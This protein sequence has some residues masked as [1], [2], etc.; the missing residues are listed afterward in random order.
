MPTIPQPKHKRF[1]SRWWFWVGL[2]VLLTLLG[3]GIYS[4]STAGKSLTAYQYLQE[5]VTV[6]TRDLD[7]RITANGSVVPDQSTSLS[8]NLPG[9]VKDI[10]VNVGDEVDKDEVLIQASSEKIK[11][12]FDGRV[13]AIQ[14]FVGQP[15]IPGTPAITMSY[16]SNHIEFFASENEVLEL[17]VGQPVTIT[18]PA[19]Q[20]GQ[21]EYSG[22]VS[23]VDVQKQ[24]AET[25]GQNSETGY[26]IKIQMDDVP[27]VVTKKVGL[28]VDVDVQ[29]GKKDGALSVE[30]GAIQYNDKHEPFVYLLPTLDD[31]FLAQVKTATDITSVLEKKSISTGFAGDEFTEVTSGLTEGQD[32]LLYVPQSDSGLPF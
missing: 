23:F 8:L 20:N 6:Q 7:R 32:V 17:A 14:D 21:D 22:T 31:T 4:A 16:R 3:A 19:Y 13:L 1:F 24:S 28:T 18:V 10:L 29:V 25:L 30:T 2:I 9:T 5:K 15:V 11:A 26:L 27:E 12:P